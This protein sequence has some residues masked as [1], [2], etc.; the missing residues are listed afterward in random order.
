[1]HLLLEEFK[2]FSQ[3]I[4]E[5]TNITS[6]N[7]SSN[8]SLILGPVSKSMSKFFSAG[9][10]DGVWSPKFSNWSLSRSPTKTR[11]PHPCQKLHPRKQNHVHELISQQK[12]L[13]S[14]LW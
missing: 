4:L 10:R 6:H 8:Q 14:Q 12:V 7:M 1:M 13:S 5:Y 9:V 3:V 11:T 2:N